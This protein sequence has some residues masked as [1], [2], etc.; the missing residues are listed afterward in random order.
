[1][2]RIRN[3]MER[4]GRSASFHGI[5]HFQ[6]RKYS[7]MKKSW[8]K[9]TNA[10]EINYRDNYLVYQPCFVQMMRQLNFHGCTWPVKCLVCARWWLNALGALSMDPWGRWAFDLS[11]LIVASFS[12]VLQCFGSETRNIYFCQ[13]FHLMGRWCF[14]SFLQQSGKICAENNEKVNCF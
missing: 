1:M 7:T 12:N 5:P 4:G 8:P 3:G 13:E 9:H 10:E 2:K 14:R 11:R 6:R